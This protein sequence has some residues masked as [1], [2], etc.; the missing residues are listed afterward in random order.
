[1]TQEKKYSGE[2]NDVATDKVV[3]TKEWRQ[4]TNKLYAENLSIGDRVFLNLVDRPVS[5]AAGVA[6]AFHDKS[7][8]SPGLFIDEGNFKFYVSGE[9]VK[10][11]LS[12]PL[13]SAS[14]TFDAKIN[15]L[16]EQAFDECADISK[17]PKM[18][19]LKKLS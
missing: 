16:A 14:K 1:M 18:S 5:F 4:R 9:Y 8:K 19:S 11:V 13:F 3:S 7:K 10:E 6:L 17:T 2:F 15:A 12:K